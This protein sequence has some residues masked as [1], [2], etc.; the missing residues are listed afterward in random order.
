MQDKVRRDAFH[1]STYS[2]TMLFALPDFWKSFEWIEQLIYQL[3][4]L[5]FVLFT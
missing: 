4:R 5:N 2:A 1:Y 3:C